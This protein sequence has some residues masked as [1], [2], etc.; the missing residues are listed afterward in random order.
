MSSPAQEIHNLIY[1]LFRNL[2]SSDRDTCACF[3][4]T[5]LQGLVLLELARKE[6]LGMQ[7]LA[8]RMQLAISTMSRVVDK[9][10]EAELILRQEDKND[11]RAVLCSLT[12]AGQK[13]AQQLAGCYNDFFNKL[14]SNL[15]PEDLTGFLKG[16]R[17]MVR[18]IQ[19]Y[20]NGC[21]CANNKS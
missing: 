17:V 18:Q 2:E 1:Q 12:E 3:G 20:A 16:L 11:R 4:V 14:V 5:P 9:L 21:G 6:P 7:Q 8:E 10:V 15:S 13:T 19:G